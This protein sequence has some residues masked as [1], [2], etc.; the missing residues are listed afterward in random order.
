MLCCPAIVALSTRIGRTVV[1]RICLAGATASGVAGYGWVGCCCLPLS[2]FLFLSHLLSILSSLPP[3][4]SSLPPLLPPF[5]SPPSL[6]LSSSVP[7]SPSSLLSH[8]GLSSRCRPPSQASFS[9]AFSPA[10][11]LP[12]SPLHRSAAHLSNCVPGVFCSLNSYS[13]AQ[14]Q[15]Y[16]RL[17]RKTRNHADGCGSQAGV[18]D[19]VSGKQSAVAL[20][21]V[22]T[23]SQL[24]VVV[25]PGTA[26]PTCL[27]PRYAAASY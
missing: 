22:A 9:D 15:L 27:R 18:T 20:S 7:P 11:L 16:P 8:S 3:L 5:L 14:A 25:G 23:A 17:H 26:R 12:L 4:Q 1:L 2:P 19:I 24:G 21:R 13:L 6:P 10:F